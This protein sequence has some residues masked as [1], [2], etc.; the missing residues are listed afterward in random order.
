LLSKQQAPPPQTLP[1]QQGVAGCPHGVQLAVEEVPLQT[2]P[3]VRQTR[4]VLVPVL[5]PVPV[6]AA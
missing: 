3:L 2:R 4:L 6:G 5:P 1:A